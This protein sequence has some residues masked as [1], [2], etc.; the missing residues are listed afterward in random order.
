[1]ITRS[2][3]QKKKNVELLHAQ[4]NERRLRFRSRRFC[5]G[6]NLPAEI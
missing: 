5:Y 1:L 3:K 6:V 2:E 4:L